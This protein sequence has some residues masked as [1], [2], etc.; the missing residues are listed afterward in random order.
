[1]VGVTK[2][3]GLLKQFQ[4]LANRAV[5]PVRRSFCT[6]MAPPREK[7]SDVGSRVLDTLVHGQPFGDHVPHLLLDRKHHLLQVD[8]DPLH[9][10]VHLRL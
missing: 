1:M 8:W 10:M 6:A 2:F 7:A 9:L 5:H 4:V 3:E